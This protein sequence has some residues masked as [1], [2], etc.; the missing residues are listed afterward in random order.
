MQAVV[1]VMARRSGTVVSVATQALNQP[2]HI[3]H[4]VEAC[5][6]ENGALPAESPECAEGILHIMVSEAAQFPEVCR[7]AGVCI[8]GIAVRL[9]VKPELAQFPF[10]WFVRMSRFRVLMIADLRF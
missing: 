6:S 1:S 3:A 5:G 4:C 10:P 2:I 7:N 9:R 8:S